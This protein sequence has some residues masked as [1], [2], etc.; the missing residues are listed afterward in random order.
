MIKEGL[1]I[2]AP[3]L[4]SLRCVKPYHQAPLFQKM[5]SIATATIVLDDSFL[6][7]DYKH[8]CESIHSSP[9]H[10]EGS[11]SDCSPEDDP[12]Y[13]SDS[14]SDAS[15]CQ[16]SEVLTYSE[17]EQG[18][19]HCKDCKCN[20]GPYWIRRGY[21]RQNRYEILGGH[22]ALGSLSNATSLELLGDAGEV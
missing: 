6:H 15:T 18:Q 12:R 19:D 5:G 3:N 9:P 22:N 7:V 1:T 16:Y 17:D 13:C 21:G 4:V 14:C 10:D 8:K 20:Y 11:D 2:A